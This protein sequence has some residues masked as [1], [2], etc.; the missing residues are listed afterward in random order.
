MW[1]PSWRL[2]TLPLWVRIAYAASMGAGLC[3]STLNVHYRSHAERHSSQT[4]S[5]AF[6]V[7]R[8]PMILQRTLLNRGHSVL[9][10]AGVRVSPIRPSELAEA[11]LHRVATGHGALSMLVLDRGDSVQGEHAHGRLYE[12][13]ELALLERHFKGGLVV[14]VGANVGNHSLVLAQLER[15]TGV[16][17]FEPNPQAFAMLQFNVAING[18][19]QR[20]TTHRLAL[21]DRRGETLLRQPHSNLGGSSLEATMPSRAGVVA[22]H[23]CEMVCGSDWLP[24]PVALIKIDVEGHELSC[25]R[26]LLPVLERDRPLLFVEVVEHHKSELLGLLDTHGYCVAE[27]FNR[28]K[29]MTNWLLKAKTD[30]QD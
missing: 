19:E 23:R 3:L 28:Y 29:G 7:D 30:G 21:S 12:P 2:L 1:W 17:A 9:R 16:I 24:D 25:L 4:G 5:R 11:S 22:E 26:G 10:S 27:E 14:D 15:T 13:E 8:W 20:I 6:T 18:L